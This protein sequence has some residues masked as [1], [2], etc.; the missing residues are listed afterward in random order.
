MESA[1]KFLLS[2][3]NTQKLIPEDNHF[4]T[5]SF[6][7]LC[8]SRDSILYRIHQFFNQ[9]FQLPQQGIVRPDLPVQFTAVRNDAFLFQ[10]TGGNSL[11]NG[12][13]FIQPTICMAAMINTLLNPGPLKKAVGHIGPCRPPEDK[14]ILAVPA[15]G[16]RILP[17]VFR[18]LGI[19]G[20]ALIALHF[21]LG[22]RHIQ[23]L[24]AGLILILLLPTLGLR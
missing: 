15:F 12:R 17:A 7:R 9:R 21:C 4:L 11:M 20:D 6:H 24:F 18:A 1:S 10:R 8:N 23:L 5:N 3:P 16:N 22:G 14:L 2:G 19:L 13:L